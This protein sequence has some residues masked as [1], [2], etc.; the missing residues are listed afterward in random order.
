MFGWEKSIP[1]VGKLFAFVI[2]LL[3]ITSPPFGTV[4]MACAGSRFEIVQIKV[5]FFQG[6]LLFFFIGYIWSIW[7]GYLCLKK[8]FQSKPE[9]EKTVKIE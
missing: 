9:T 8:S 3:C 1:L 2:M 7:W 5:A 4:L 6:V